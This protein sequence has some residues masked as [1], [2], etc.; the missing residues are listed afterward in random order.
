MSEVLG[1]D[2]HPED[3]NGFT[4]LQPAKDRALVMTT[5]NVRFGSRLNAGREDL[6]LFCVEEGHVPGLSLAGLL[7][8]YV[9]GTV[10]ALTEEPSSELYLA[11]TCLR[12]PY[13]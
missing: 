4:G 1:F 5:R 8:A 3:G 6:L 11:P 9:V 13:N 12:I 2:G 10:Y 7:S